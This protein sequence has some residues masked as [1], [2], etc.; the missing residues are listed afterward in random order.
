MVAAGRMPISVSLFRPLVT[1][2]AVDGEWFAVVS[3]GVT[4]VDVVSWPLQ[5]C[6]F[7]TDTSAVIR[8][9]LY[10]ASDEAAFQ[11]GEG[12]RFAEVHVPASKLR[13][14]DGS[15]FR[16]WFGLQRGVHHEQVSAEDAEV[17]YEANLMLA[18][19]L[20]TP[21]LCCTV[22]D[23]DCPPGAAE[24]ELLQRSLVQH[25][26]MII[27]MHQQLQA[28]WS[29]GKLTFAAEPSGELVAKLADVRGDER[30]AAGEFREEVGR[31]SD[32]VVD[33]KQRL[34]SNDRIRL[35]CQER[36]AA[37]GEELVDAGEGRLELAPTG[38]AE[39]TRD[40]DVHRLAEALEAERAASVAERARADALQEKLQALQQN[41]QQARSGLPPQLQ[42]LAAAKA[43]SGDEQ[44]LLNDWAQGL[45][46][47]IEM[48]W[49]Q[50]KELKSDLEGMRLACGQESQQCADAQAQA[51]LHERQSADAQ[52]EAAL[53]E[54]EVTALREMMLADQCKYQEAVAE[55][56]WRAE[57]E[58]NEIRDAAHGEID[59]LQSLLKTRASEHKEQLQQLRAELQASGAAAGA[60]DDVEQCLRSDIQDL[61]VAYDQMSRQTKEQFEEMALLQERMTQEIIDLRKEPVRSPARELGSAHE[62][63]LEAS[64]RLREELEAQQAELRELRQA[65]DLDAKNVEARLAECEQAT[66]ASVREG[67][68]DC[69]RRVAQLE[70]QL[71]AAGSAARRGGLSPG[72]RVRPAAAAQGAASQAADRAQRGG[73]KPLLDLAQ[74]REKVAEVDQELLRLG[75]RKG[76]LRES[77]LS[78][79]SGGFGNAPVKHTPLI[80]AMAAANA[81]S[82]AAA[83]AGAGN[84]RSPTRTRTTPPPFVA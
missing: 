46:A 56:R 43:A 23:E 62:A 8:I 4:Q 69:E 27:R 30:A 72:A 60:H 19:N 61:E 7:E 64:A 52:A 2:D 48:L 74:A 26:N 84:A 38:R 16:G 44:G 78:A 33:L 73:E 6:R 82:V 67:Y 29:Q 53:H 42:Q 32:E 39:Q 63:T 25:S 70:V 20:L 54:R 79:V 31:L 5:H 75:A 80:R 83:A 1:V 9:E 41:A 13:Q 58:A 65:K 50:N 47:D 24:E 55:A 17:L 11:R 45:C 49:Q 71:R 66:A 34:E 81:A 37:L 12:R 28:L 14:P 76:P 77:Q 68:R 51:A 22:M 57:R 18:Q 3:D 35:F 36:L 21:K 15:L 40:A 10:L 59:E